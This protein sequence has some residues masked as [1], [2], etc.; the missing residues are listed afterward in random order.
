KELMS[1][2]GA[3]VEDVRV[4]GDEALMEYTARFDKVELST[5]RVSEKELRG[6]AARAD[7][8]LR[9]ALRE[10]IANVREFHERQVERSWTFNP[11]KGVQLG[12]RITP[13]E[14]VGLYVPGGTAAYP[15]SVVMNVVPAQVAGVERI[16]V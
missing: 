6:C 15:S 4:H 12:Q 16:V 5:L 3:I 11:R 1:V 8:R 14:R 13:L 7:E 2:A 10:A 9:G